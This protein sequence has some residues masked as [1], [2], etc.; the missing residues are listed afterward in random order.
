[1]EVE[2]RGRH[3]RF[4][5]VPPTNQ[6]LTLSWF[7]VETY[8]GNTIECPP[9]LHYPGQWFIMGPPLF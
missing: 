7:Y 6:F 1:M 3:A 9:H 8:R 2:K 5:A 4:A